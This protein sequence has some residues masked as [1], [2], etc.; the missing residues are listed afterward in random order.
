MKHLVILAAAALLA[1]AAH[2][3]E[4]KHPP[5]H[6]KSN[7]SAGATAGPSTSSSTST[8]GPSTSGA[9]AGSTTG[10]IT[11]GGAQASTG[12]ATAGASTGPVTTGPATAGAKAEA[13]A[14][15][16]GASVGD[17]VVNVQPGSTAPAGGPTAV[18]QST[19]SSTSTRALA[20]SLPPPVSSVVAANGCLV[21]GASAQAIGWN[22]WSSA[23]PRA[24]SDPDCVLMRAADQAEHACQWLTAATIRAEIVRRASGVTL[25]VSP[26]LQ[27]IDPMA[28]LAA[29]APKVVVPAAP[30]THVYAL[31]GHAGAAQAQEQSTEAPAAQPVPAPQPP[32][33]AAVTPRPRPTPR[34]VAPQAVT[35]PAVTCGTGETAQCVPQTPAPGSFRSITEGAR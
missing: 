7:S 29:R 21:A 10:A 24:F 14:S 20:I 2:A 5:A 35:P 18:Q 33:A 13:G 6:Q 32:T 19:T 34:P 25:P 8:S 27:D 15:T 17:V 23:D 31:G 3:T 11:T 22:F 30:Q 28:C 1:A 12:P 26:S 4:P 16:S 9:V